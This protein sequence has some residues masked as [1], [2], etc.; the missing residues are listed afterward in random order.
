MVECSFERTGMINKVHIF[1]LALLSSTVPLWTQVDRS[2]NHSATA[3][4]TPLSVEELLR[5]AEQLVRNSGDQEAERL[6][7]QAHESLRLAKESADQHDDRSRIEH[8]R[9]T[10][11][12]L[13]QSLQKVEDSGLGLAE[14]ATKEQRRFEE[15]LQRSREA[16]N[17]C[18][19][20]HAEKLFARAQKQSASIQTAIDQ[21]EYRLAMGMTN[22]ATRLLLRVIDLCQGRVLTEREGT[23]EELEL[24]RQA[25]ITAHERFDQVGSGQSAIILQRVERLQQKAEMAINDQDYPLAFRHLELAHALVARL[26][27]QETAS[28]RLGIEINRLRNQLLALRQAPHA[29]TYSPR[30]LALLRNAE[31]FARDAA[32]LQR[33]GRP[34]IALISVLLADRFLN[35]LR[36]PANETKVPDQEKSKNEIKSVQEQ[37]NR[38][39][40]LSR[41]EENQAL[42]D[43]AKELLS[44]A[45]RFYQDQEYSLVIQFCALSRLIMDK[46]NP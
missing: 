41:G 34:R 6:L 39:E 4:P 21:S 45:Q 30:Q 36:T 27:N 20:D 16:L 2:A 28:E 42:I 3:G 11:S 7:D 33:A 23:L 8:L 31:R 12:L 13:Q 19:N 26:W 40:E 25:L 18:H 15:L 35:L 9:V 37:L 10:R 43:I 5:K 24:L 38:M 14:K 17:G 29:Q 22:N 1:F 32:R 46:L 44:H